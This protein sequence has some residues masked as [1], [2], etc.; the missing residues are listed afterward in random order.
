MCVH[1]KV[2]DVEK[3]TFVQVNCFV[4]FVFKRETSF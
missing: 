4:S 1:C 2:R 3:K